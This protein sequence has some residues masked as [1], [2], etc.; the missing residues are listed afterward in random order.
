[1]SRIGHR[2]ATI[3]GILALDLPVAFVLTMM[4]VPVWS[5]IESRWGIESVG[6][7]GPAAWCYG[8]VFAGVAAISLGAYLW[9]LAHPT[10]AATD[11]AEP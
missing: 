1:M 9:R 11:E 5:A 8:V 6:H 7:S 4:L 2:V 10:V 3:A